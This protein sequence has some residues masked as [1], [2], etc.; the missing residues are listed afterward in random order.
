MDDKDM[1]KP[2][3]SSLPLDKDDIKNISADDLDELLG[4]SAEHSASVS[5]NTQQMYVAKDGDIPEEYLPEDY[6]PQDEYVPEEG[7]IPEQYD[8]QEDY[9]G[10]YAGEY[11]DE[12]ADEAYPEDIAY[13]ETA[14]PVIGDDEEAVLEDIPESQ[15]LTEETPDTVIK[16]EAVHKAEKT[17]E[18]KNK[19]KSEK[20][21]ITAKTDDNK[22]PKKK[23]RKRPRARTRFNGSIFGGLI[24]VTIILTV[25]LILAVGGITMGMEYYG[26]GKSDNDISFNIPEGADNDQI[27]DLLI[28]NGIIKNKKLFL[29]ALKIQKPKTL[30]PGDITL[31]P[32]LGYGDIIEEMQKQRESYQTVTLTF[33]EGIYLSTV[34]NML[35]EN[36]VCTAKDFLYQY[37]RQQGYDFENY[38][39]EDLDVFYAREGFLFPD[40][41]EFYVDDDPYHVAM[42]MREHYDSKLTEE[43]Y[44][45]M[46]SMGF[47][48]NQTITLASIVQME[49]AN[50]EEMPNVASVFINRL[51]DKDTF[52]KLESNTTDKYIED[53]IKQYAGSD[54]LIQYYSELY[55][56]YVCKGLPAGPICN[57][58]MDAIMAVLNASDTD[59]YYF[60][61]NVET[62]ETFYAKTL[63]EHEENM[64]KAGLVDAPEPVEEDDE[65][66]EGEDEDGEGEDGEGDGEEYYD[67]GYYE[68]W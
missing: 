52:P 4:L 40:T 51:H 41:Y 50:V 21:D 44:T 42:V 26:I 56:T 54:E 3:G 31:Q 47:D 59:Y 10:E 29:F 22:K 11:T 16:D 34:A 61:N 66:E 12:Y 14:A 58:G 25:S 46:N 60:C 1:N 5:Q 57:P 6:I 45:K 36:K 27:A 68:N 8:T 67:D 64:I 39:P 20:S 49:A 7:Y 9:S 19:K 55:D 28:E 53:V 13:E 35:E 17:D 37:N 24:L 15:D 32:S 23:K 62:G 43:M 38:L 2:E 63:E 33:P 30:Y 18:S 65:D 48:L